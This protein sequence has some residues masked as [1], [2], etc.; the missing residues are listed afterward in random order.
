MVSSWYPF[1]TKKEFRQDTAPHVG[2]LPFLWK[3][4]GAE[5]WP[6]EEK[7]K[8]CFGALQGA[9]WLPPFASWNIGK[10]Y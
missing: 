10:D 3:P 1:T 8:S 2:G 6:L 9:S 7:V 4:R 5:A